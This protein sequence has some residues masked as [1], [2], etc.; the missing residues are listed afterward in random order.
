MKT[1]KNIDFLNREDLDENN[2]LEAVKEQLQ[3]SHPELSGDNLTI[4]AD[5]MV[6]FDEDVIEDNGRFF[7]F[8]EAGGKN[9]NIVFNND[10]NSNDLGF[11]GSL[12]YCKGYIESHNGSSHSYFADYKGGTVAVVCNQDGEIA[13]EAE[14]K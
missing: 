12:D 7:T 14:V 8:T 3:D 1:Y 10:T 4:V 2:L 6:R 5:L 13:F 11:H 9:Y